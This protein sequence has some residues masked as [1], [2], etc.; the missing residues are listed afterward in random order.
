MINIGN[1]IKTKDHV[2]INSNKS[3]AVLICG[4]RGSGKSYTMGVIVEELLD[5]E[6]VLVIIIDPM[7]I[8]YTM[9][10]PNINQEQ[11]LWDW[12]L[13]SK[14][15]PVKVLV[16]GDPIELYGGRE[17]VGAM[18]RKGI[19]FRTFKLN[20]SDLSPDAWCELFDVSIS[21]V[22]G[23]GL[24]RAVQQLSRSKKNN[25]S[26][27]DIIDSIGSDPL[28]ADKT[29]QAL[30]NRLE[31]A[32][33]WGIFSEWYQELWEIFDKHS[34]NIVDLSV[35]DP[36]PL[37][38][39]NLILNVL[40]KDI[41]RR[42]TIARRKEEL[43]LSDDL[44]KVWMLID[45]AHQFVPSGKSTLSKEILIRWAKEGRQPGLSL[46]VASQQPSAIDSE[47]VTQCDVVIAQK[48]TNKDDIS[49]L[50]ALNQDYMGGEMK[51]YIRGLKRKGEAVV[52]NDEEEKVRIIQVR[53]RKSYHGGAEI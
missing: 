8:Y 22:M 24:F 23:I 44:P 26:V 46:L 40:A 6:D 49:A 1:E 17:I 37:G 7:G 16:P 21:D 20:P 30:V 9:Q 50:N 29:R 10:Q 42:R 32:I 38:R 2:Y 47:V 53:P 34:V 43:K 45:E 41:F 14:G 3:H 13:S 31:M 25:F 51:T 33:D 4:K 28:V 11:L 35:L 27:R 48:L 19:T 52:V 15:V 12:G 18:E 5:A 39:R 36:G